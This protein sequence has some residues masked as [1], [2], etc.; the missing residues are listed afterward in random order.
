[1]ETSTEEKVVKEESK[2]EQKKYLKSDYTYTLKPLLIATVIIL[3]ACILVIF[4]PLFSIEGKDGSQKVS[5]AKFSVLAIRE[6]TGD[7]EI[8]AESTPILFSQDNFVGCFI[9]LVFS[10]WTIP[11]LVI[12]LIKIGYFKWDAVGFAIEVIFKLFKGVIVILALFISII[13]LSDL[14]TALSQ[15]TN[16]SNS[17]P[18]FSDGIFSYLFIYIGLSIFGI[19]FSCVCCVRNPLLRKRKKDYIYNSILLIVHIVLLIILLAV[20][21]LTFDN[22]KFSWSSINSSAYYDFIRVMLIAHGKEAELVVCAIS[23][24]CVLFPYLVISKIFNII[25][26]MFVPEEAIK[27][28]VGYP[29]ELDEGSYKGIGVLIRCENS[30]FPIGTIIVGSILILINL[31][32]VPIMSGL[33][34]WTGVI[35]TF[36]IYNLIIGI[37]F[38][39]AGIGLIIL[40][41][42]YFKKIEK[43]IDDI[44]ELKE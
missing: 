27:E 13:F 33:N 2:N 22:H 15:N 42:K 30:N 35:S 10:L 5:F 7:K 19:I 14:S 44:A 38:V 1:M 31:L 18:A 9:V 28:M 36:N 3:V 6:L 40:Q 39:V 12:L 4:I 17:G 32:Y 29:N 24:L 20:P 25:K 16:S 23:W 34:L 43:E 26:D 8:F 41:K 21:P 37:V 11:T